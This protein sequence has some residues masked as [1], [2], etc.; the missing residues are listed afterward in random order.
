[1][2]KL[3]VHRTDLEWLLRERDAIKTRRHAD[4]LQAH[5]DQP[6]ELVRDRLAGITR[7]GNDACG[8]VHRAAGSGVSAGSG[9][10]AGSR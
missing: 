8:A 9:G 1:M 5:R 2:R 6:P 3:L 4:A 10:R 7:A